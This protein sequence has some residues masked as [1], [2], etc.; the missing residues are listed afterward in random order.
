MSRNTHVKRLVRIGFK[1]SVISSVAIWLRKAQNRELN[2][3]G[4]D[5]CPKGKA[6]E[7]GGRLC[8]AE[9]TPRNQ[10]DISTYLVTFPFTNHPFN[11]A[12]IFSHI[13]AFRSDNFFAKLFIL[14][15]T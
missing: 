12:N 13:L 3:H 8:L 2:K 14:W 1:T 9:Q 6:Q 10:A 7:W 15:L 11:G 5:L 4:Q